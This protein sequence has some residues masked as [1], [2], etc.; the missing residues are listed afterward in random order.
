MAQ[1]GLKMND[2]PKAMTAQ[3]S[4][5]LKPQNVPSAAD[6]GVLP[7]G[8][9]GLDEPCHAYSY[10]ILAGTSPEGYQDSAR[11]Y[12]V[13]LGVGD[14]PLGYDFAAPD[15]EDVAGL[16]GI[17]TDAQ[18]NVFAGGIVAVIDSI[19]TEN[20]LYQIQYHGDKAFAALV[21][22]GSDVTVYDEG[23]PIAITCV[24]I[25]PRRVGVGKSF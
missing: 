18:G 5:I 6:T 8:A 12:T 10:Q 25:A 22:T 20:Q 19:D 21:I 1:K 23:L 14:S 7:L 15:A 17:G 11:K 16:D 3:V 13:R 9:P 4:M 2:A 24:G